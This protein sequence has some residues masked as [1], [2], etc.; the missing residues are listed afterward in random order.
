MNISLKNYKNLENEITS[1]YLL[2]GRKNVILYIYNLITGIDK[3]YI[4]IE[5]MHFDKDDLRSL[6]TEKISITACASGL[7]VKTE[8]QGTYVTVLSIDIVDTFKK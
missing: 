4:Y 5:R 6:G 1:F 7:L 8:Y 3:F 2:T